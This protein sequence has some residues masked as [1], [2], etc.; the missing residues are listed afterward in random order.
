VLVGDR[1]SLDGSDQQPVFRLRNRVDEGDAAVALRLLGGDPF[2]RHAAA[3][4]VRYQ[5]VVSAT[6]KSPASSVHT[7]RIF[8]CERA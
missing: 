4:G 3:I 5:A 7:R 2:L 8:Q 1:S 6:A